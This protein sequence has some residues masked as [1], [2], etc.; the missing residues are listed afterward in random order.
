MY[1]FLICLFLVSTITTGGAQLLSVTRLVLGGGAI[2]LYA[3]IGALTTLQDSGF[4]NMQNCT[5]VNDGALLCAFLVAGI[6]AAAI[7]ALVLL[8]SNY[9]RPLDYP[10]V[11]PTS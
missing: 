8:P 7:D 9:S 6:P 11:V 3:G 5:G 2:G 1:K 10:T 4:Y